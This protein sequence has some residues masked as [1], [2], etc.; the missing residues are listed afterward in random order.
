MDGTLD[1][2]LSVRMENAEIPPADPNDAGG[3]EQELVCHIKNLEL[4]ADS[5]TIS[6]CGRRKGAP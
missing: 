4:L 5:K 6:P 3:E 1:N 2:A